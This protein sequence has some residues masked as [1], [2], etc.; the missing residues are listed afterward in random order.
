VNPACHF[1]PF[2][3]L[4]WTFG[5]GLLEFT[6][7]SSG[8]VGLGQLINFKLKQG[9]ENSSSDSGKYELAIGAPD[10]NQDDD[11]KDKTKIF[12][13]NAKHIFRNAPNHLSDTPANRKLLIDLTSNENNFLGIDQHGTKWFGQI[14]SDGRQV[15]ATVRDNYVRNGGIN[16]TIKTFDPKTGLSQPL[17]K[18]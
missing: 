5:P 14:L 2:I 17:R 11:K 10:P 16:T 8:L 3:A 7:L 13:K 6:S 1:A 9:T 18:R 4:S 15:W 12:E